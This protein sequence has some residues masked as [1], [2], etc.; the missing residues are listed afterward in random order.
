MKTLCILL[1]VS[2]LY[3]CGKKDECESKQYFA[4]PE[5]I[6][7]S[8]PYQ[9]KTAVI[10][11]TN[12]GKKITAIV[13]RKD[14]VDRLS[15]DFCEE[16][17]HVNLN[18]PEKPGFIEIVQRASYDRKPNPTLHINMYSPEDYAKGNQIDILFSSDGKMSSYLGGRTSTFYETLTINGKVYNKVVEMIEP[19]G[20]QAFYNATHGVIQF[21]TP[22][23]I[24]TT[25][26][27]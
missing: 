21:K 10:F 9:D 15:R 14:W 22:D 7:K 4:T 23:G 12:N 18:T 25:R 19:N 2:L 3:G 24:I 6:R 20:L 17:I 13:N 16:I 27:N 1:F 11:E 8:I 5:I 26:T